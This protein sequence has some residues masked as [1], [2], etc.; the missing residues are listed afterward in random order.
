[1][2]ELTGRR[3]GGSTALTLRDR[4]VLPRQIYGQIYSPKANSLLF[5]DPPPKLL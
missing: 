1:M 2:C 3:A 5:E 4:A